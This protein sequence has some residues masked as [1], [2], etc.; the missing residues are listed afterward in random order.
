[1]LEEVCFSNETD[2]NTTKSMLEKVVLLV[3]INDD[4]ET[5]EKVLDWAR[6]KQIPLSWKQEECIGKHCPILIACHENYTKCITV[7]YKYGYKILLPDEDRDTIRT[8][9]ETED[10][11]INDWY[12]Y[13]TLYFGRASV[14]DR[15]RTNAIPSVDPIERFIK[16][17]AVANPH[18]ILT[19]FLENT[20]GTSKDLQQYDPI[21]RSLA[22][23][24]YSKHL[25]QYYVHYSQEYKEISKV[26]TTYMDWCAMTSD[27]SLEL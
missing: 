15:L 4:H 8:V 13:Y 25:S 26:N 16:F 7:L 17:K 11:V 14:G 3:T 22:L 9:L 18:Y 23:A 6:G 21:R 1:M 19:E 24:R 5:L 20:A 12:F 27:H 2:R 10:A